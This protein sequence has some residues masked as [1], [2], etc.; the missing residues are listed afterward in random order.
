MA[1]IVS[2]VEIARPPDEVFSY[3]TDPSRFVEWQQGI[4]SGCMEG[5]AMNAPRHPDQGRRGHSCLLRVRLVGNWRIVA[6]PPSRTRG[7]P[8]AFELADATIRLS[9]LR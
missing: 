5:A 9:A 1:P 4:V 3:A 7:R 6:T 8:T 2:K